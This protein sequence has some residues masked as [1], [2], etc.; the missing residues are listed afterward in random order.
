MSYRAVLFD[1]DGTLLDT[2]EDLAD[3]TNAALMQLGFPPHPLD[4]YRY[5]VG[6]GV[7]NLILRTLP[8]AHRDEPTV[9][10]A[11]D[12]M[13]RIYGE[14][15]ADKT[16]PYPGIPE[17]LDALAARGVKMAVLSNKPHESTLLC[18]A[19]LLP[20]WRFDAV[21][22]QSKAVPPKP[23]LAGVRTIIAQL[24][25]PAEQ[26]LYLGDT[27]TDMQ[28]AN[29]AGMFAVGALWGFRPAD[30]LREAGARA[31][32]GKPADLLALL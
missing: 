17:L 6:D 10:R 20:R 16:R 14:H 13:R 29:A 9:A 5:F 28:T 12:L 2:L 15:W 30:E 11:V 8:E 25:V 31:M 18:V 23:D 4:A 24:G 3:S 21:I 27:N 32:I 19:R 7:T 1:L 22:G 26:F